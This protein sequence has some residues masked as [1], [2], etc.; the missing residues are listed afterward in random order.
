[1]DVFDYAM[2]IELDGKAFYEKRAQLTTHQGLRNILL[3]MAED[4]QKHYEIFK[5]MKEGRG[6]DAMG[7]GTQILT[8][9]KGF[10][11]QLAEEGVPEFPADELAAWK[12]LRETEENAEKFY[13]EK[14]AEATDETSRKALNLI[15][16]EERKHH[17]L[18]DNM[19]EFLTRPSTWLEDAEW[20]NIEAY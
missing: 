3:E 18:I 5:E 12:E 16:D 14:A 2:K 6:W 11:E 4:E 13:R 17:H 8:R 20:R 19:I 7:E 15:A 1:M 9:A 10:F